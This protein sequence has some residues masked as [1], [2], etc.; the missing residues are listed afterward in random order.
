MVSLRTL[1]LLYLAHLRAR[2]LPELLA[3]LGIAAGVALLF[4]VQVANKSVT[5]SFEQLSED[6]AG[7]ASLEVA[8]RGPQGFD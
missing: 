1:A 7:R 4:A 8:A 2:P 5:G 6:I 3:V